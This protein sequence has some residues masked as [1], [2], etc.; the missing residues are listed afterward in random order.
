MRR[1]PFGTSLP[2]S[3]SR[4]L[5]ELHQRDRLLTG[6]ALAMLVLMSLALV[7]FAVDARTLRDLSVWAKPI[8]F[9]LSTA[10][11]ALTMAWFIGLL[12]EAVR[13]SGAVQAMVWT[14]IATSLFEV[15]YISGQAAMGAASHYNTVEV[16]HA[17]MYGLMAVAAVLLSS[18]QVVLA[19]QIARSAAAVE[20]ALFRHAVIAGLVMSCVLSIASGALLGANQPPPGAGLPLLGWH[21]PTGDLRPAHFVGLHAQQLIPLAGF[22][23]QR[24]A[25]RGAVSIATLFGCFYAVVISYL[26]LWWLLCRAG[27]ATASGG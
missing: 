8:K 3:V 18:T 10:L 9:M 13:G 22:A 7:A 2:G 4:L 15:L 1:L 27:L 19:W 5:A 26:A 20:M 21:L 6:Y 12:P 24:L 11:F 25:Q 16:F 23:L 17:R 14:L